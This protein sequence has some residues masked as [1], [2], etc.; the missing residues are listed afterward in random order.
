[1][2][3]LLALRSF[4]ASLRPGQEGTTTCGRWTTR[5][6]PPYARRC[7][8]L[9]V[10]LRRYAVGSQRRSASAESMFVEP[11]TWVLSPRVSRV[12]RKTEETA[13]AECWRKLWFPTQQHK[14]ALWCFCVWKFRKTRSDYFSAI[15][16]SGSE[17]QV[18]TVFPSFPEFSASICSIGFSNPHSNQHRI[19]RCCSSWVLL[20][21]TAPR[22]WFLT[23]F[24]QIQ[25]PNRY[26]IQIPNSHFYAIWSFRWCLLEFCRWTQFVAHHW[27]ATQNMDLRPKCWQSSET[28]WADPGSDARSWTPNWREWTWMIGISRP[29]MKNIYSWNHWCWNYWMICRLDMLVCQVQGS[30]RNWGITHFDNVNCSVFLALRGDQKEQNR[31]WETVDGQVAASFLVVFQ[32]VT[33]DCASRKQCAVALCKHCTSCKIQQYPTVPDW[34]AGAGRVVRRHGN[35]AGRGIGSATS[36]IPR[37]IW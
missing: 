37:F 10:Q 23:D 12:L 25:I 27:R 5:R 15:Q 33:L 26:Q 17:L 7:T 24:C 30:S 9:P 16:G 1:M 13:N 4:A 20:R 6:T 18:G 2:S 3:V 31:N 36:W 14:D 21:K 11:M 29:S 34:C 19:S 32:S 28:I 22:P 35:G 8:P